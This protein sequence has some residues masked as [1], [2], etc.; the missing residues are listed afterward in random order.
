MIAPAMDPTR[1]GHLLIDMF[2]GLQVD[3]RGVVQEAERPTTRKTRIIASNQHVLRVDRET[4]REISTASFD[5]LVT[6]METV[7]PDIDVVLA[8]PNQ[9][10]SVG[11]I[12]ANI[13]PSL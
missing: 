9:T 3:C 5:R 10:F 11:S 7:M 1:H 6:F 13:G 12:A 4:K 8:V 2:N